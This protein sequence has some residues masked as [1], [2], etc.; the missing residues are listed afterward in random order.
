MVARILG[1]LLFCVSS[2]LAQQGTI[3]LARPGKGEYV[4]DLASMRSAASLEDD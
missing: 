1:I 4:R 3:D 2:A